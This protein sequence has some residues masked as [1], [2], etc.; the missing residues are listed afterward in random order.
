[1]KRLFDA[2]WHCVRLEEFWLIGSCWLDVG[3]V[4]VL[5]LFGNRR[6]STP[7]IGL[8]RG[9]NPLTRDAPRPDRGGATPWSG[10]VRGCNPLTRDAW[11]LTR[12]HAS[13]RKNG[14]NSVLLQA[15]RPR[16]GAIRL[17]EGSEPPHQRCSVIRD[18]DRCARHTLRS[19]ATPETGRNPVERISEGLQPP[20]QIRSTSGRSAPRRGNK[21]G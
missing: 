5:D 18:A 20:H 17:G 10:L 6:G 16:D 1:M 14:I 19:C 11:S 9:C 4:G 12:E 21:V 8:V 15:D 13:E 3:T 7:W 2:A